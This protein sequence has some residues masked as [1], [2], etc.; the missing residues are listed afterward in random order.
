MRTALGLD[1][2]FREPLRFAPAAAG[3]DP[4]DFGK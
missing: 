2:T 4:F 1:A 3:R